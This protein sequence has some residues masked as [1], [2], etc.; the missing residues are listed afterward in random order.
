MTVRLGH[1]WLVALALAVSAGCGQ[2][3]FTEGPQ[4][5]PPSMMAGAVL[6]F[7]ADLGTV[8]AVGGSARPGQE[9]LGQRRET[10]RSLEK[11][12]PRSAALSAKITLAG[13]HAQSDVVVERELVRVRAEADGVDLVRPLVLDPRL[14]DVGGEDP[15]LEQELVVVLQVVEDGLQ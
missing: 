6:A 14:D 4:P 11:R 7:D 15:A 1:W 9:T 13:G 8:V 3:T 5:A 12:F 10:P 2:P